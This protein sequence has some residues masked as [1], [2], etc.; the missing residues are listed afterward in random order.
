M[1][2]WTS[3]L[4]D[5]LPRL[6]EVFTF[7]AIINGCIFLLVTITYFLVGYE[8]DK[9]KCLV[10]S[11]GSFKLA[12]IFTVLAILCPSQ[13]RVNEI[14]MRADQSI[15]ETYNFVPNVELQDIE[16]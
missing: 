9:E 15:E 12:L 14:L 1:G 16:S 8:L 11:K 5:V 13:N 7:L 2:L 6:N 3:Y 10:V 4:Y